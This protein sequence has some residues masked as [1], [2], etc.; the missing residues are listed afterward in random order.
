[1]LWQLAVMQMLPSAEASDAALPMQTQTPP[2]QPSSL[3]HSSKLQTLPNG[4]LWQVAVA[5]G[6]ADLHSLLIS[7]HGVAGN[8]VLNV[9]AEATLRVSIGGPSVAPLDADA[10]PLDPPFDPPELEPCAS[11][12]LLAPTELPLVPAFFPP[13]KV[14]SGPG[15]PAPTP[16]AGP[17]PLPLDE[18]VPPTFLPQAISV[19]T[20]SASLTLIRYFFSKGVRGNLRATQ[21]LRTSANAIWGSAK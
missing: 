17:A 18:P 11:L 6:L 12:P 10:A 8:A 4:P 2:S 15:K 3:W 21:R 13:P 20:H 1:L 5:D 7:L 14:L 16:R 9:H 19:N